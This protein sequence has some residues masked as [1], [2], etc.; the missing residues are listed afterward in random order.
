MSTAFLG[1]CRE[2]IA[3]Y[4]ATTYYTLVLI[5]SEAAFIADAYESSGPNVGIANWAFSITLVTE[6]ADSNA[7]LFAAH[8]QIPRLLLA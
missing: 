2:V 4:L 8:N 7:R 6:T 3:T 5:V 1:F